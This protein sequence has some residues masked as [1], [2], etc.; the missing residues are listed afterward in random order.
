MSPENPSPT[1]VGEPAAAPLVVVGSIAYDTIETPLG[2][3]EDC[4]GGSGTFFSLAAA[5]F[6][7]PS[8]VAV[9]GEDF[10][11]EDLE[12]LRAHKVDLAG[13]ERAPGLTFRWGGKYHD[14]MNGRDTLF[15][16]LNVFERFEP[17]L[18]N[19]QKGAGFVFLG[20]IQPKLQDHVLEQVR[21]PRFVAADTM[22]LWISIA[23]QDLVEVL[24]RVDCL[25]V[26]DEEARQL[27]G[28]RSVLLAAREIQ[29]M[30]PEM[31]I[32]KRGEH[33]AILF[34]EKDIFYV[35]AFPLDKVVDPTG[36]GDTFAGGFVGY[37]HK[38]GD[39]TPENVRRAMV[40][41]SLMASFC[42]EGYGVERLKRID[43][44]AI[45]DRY[46]A[47]AELTRFG[48]LEL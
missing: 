35:P 27:T 20:N 28:K 24:R 17:H 7:T 37:L 18:S 32:I 21:S 19:E 43:R 5:A 12:L 39:L 1:Q 26:N 11:E 15:T 29:A 22:N 44:G 23:R 25:F 9:V 48:A 38:S 16:A 31:V 13:L 3:R 40:V 30:G 34:N 2:A 10:R 47:F 33:G 14:D 42:V 45:R 36:A 41:G 46:Q 8:V 4:L 6:T